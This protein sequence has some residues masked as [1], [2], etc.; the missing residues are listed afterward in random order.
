MRA[1]EWRVH[2]YTHEMKLMLVSSRSH[3]SLCCVAHSSSLLYVFLVQPTPRAYDVNLTAAHKINYCR[4]KF[5]FRNPCEKWRDGELVGDDH[6][7]RRDA[8]PR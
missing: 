2:M 6:S 8:A 5:N 4:A 1:T 3:A 7:S